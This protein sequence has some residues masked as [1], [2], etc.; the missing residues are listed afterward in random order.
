MN[1][2]ENITD[3]YVIFHKLVNMKMI[4]MTMSNIQL[5]S[6]FVNNMSPE[7]DRFVTAVKLNKGLR[8]TNYEQLYAYLHQHEKHVVYD[9]QLRDKLNPTSTTDP[10]A[11]I[12]NVQTLNQP[13]HDQVFHHSVP[14]TQN[15]TSTV[16]SS[17]KSPNVMSTQLD[18]GYSH[19]D[20]MIDNLSNQVSLLVQ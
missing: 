3:Y 19:T 13:S 16:Q 6:K 5:N 10:L 9:H 20:K 2:G 4:R 18:L 8:N 14:T 1:P 11:F 15:Q 12:S 17:V 7:W